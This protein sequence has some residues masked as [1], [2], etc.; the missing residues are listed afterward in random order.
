MLNF[1][2]VWV[3]SGH[4]GISSL[5]T[6]AADKS[7]TDKVEAILGSPSYWMDGGFRNGVFAC[8]A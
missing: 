7:I 4:E 5:G 3:R 8:S 1:L 6:S 2:V